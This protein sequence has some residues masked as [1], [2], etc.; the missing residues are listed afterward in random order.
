MSTPAQTSVSTNSG[1][2]LTSTVMNN[3]SSE[4]KKRRRTQMIRFFTAAGVSLVCS[5]VVFRGI[6]S[7][8]Y[9]P[10]LFQANHLPPSF[11]K[12]QEAITAIGYATLLAT[13]SF[14]MFIFG[15]A[16]VWDIT[17]VQDFGVRLKTWLGG[18]EN[19]AKISSMKVDED[20]QQ[21]ESDLSNL[22]AGNG[23]NK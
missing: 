11:S 13:S 23:S 7:R 20:S 6:Q 21:L 18:A 3:A 1:S 12:K 8:R 5:R 15:G 16:W 17:N 2:I 22:L 10:N 14:S 9:I 4:Y 19:Q